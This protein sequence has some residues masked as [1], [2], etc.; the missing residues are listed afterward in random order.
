[1]NT[2]QKR[3]LLIV[4]DNEVIAD[5]MKEIFSTLVDE[6]IVALDGKEGL[7]ALMKN[8]NISCVVSDVLM[9]NLNGIKFIQSVRE[10]GNNVPFIF[11][12]SFG[13]DELLKKVVEYGALD[14]VSKPDLEALFYAVD[15]AFKS[16]F[17]RDEWEKSVEQLR[18]EFDNLLGD[19]ID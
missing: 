17:Y 6:T 10:Q 2:I 9:P 15:T 8:S 7:S 11:F 5:Q 1:L 19:L 16:D 18:S 3:I 14:F 4:E 13:Q 12:S